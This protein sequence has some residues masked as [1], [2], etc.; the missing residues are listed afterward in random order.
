MYWNRAKGGG[1]CVLRSLALALKDVSWEFMGG[2]DDQVA[3]LSRG[4]MILHL[5]FWICYLAA[6]DFESMSVF[7]FLCIFS[8]APEWWWEHQLLWVLQLVSM[9]AS[10]LLKLTRKVFVHTASCSQYSKQIKSQ[11]KVIQRSWVSRYH[12]GL[13]NTGNM[14]AGSHP[15]PRRMHHIV[16]CI[17][18][19][20][21]PHLETAF[22]YSPCCA[23]PARQSS[24]LNISLKQ[25]LHPRTR[26]H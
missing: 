6:S 8:S 2:R 10:N 4:G 13:H 23:S 1:R 26:I 21:L 5:Y 12:V 19:S 25:Q 24:Q 7:L 22:P 3:L 15:D 20:A 14:A 16:F 17:W 9:N 18:P 11:S